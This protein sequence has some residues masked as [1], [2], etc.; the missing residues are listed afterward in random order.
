MKEKHSDSLSQHI[1][2]IHRV[3][4]SLQRFSHLILTATLWGGLTLS[5]KETKA[6]R[7]EVTCPSSHSWQMMEPGP[8]VCKAHALPSTLVLDLKAQWDWLLQTLMIILLEA[9]AGPDDP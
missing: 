5:Y 1:M 7:N 6:Q 9:G 2:S 4:N 8:S 3:L